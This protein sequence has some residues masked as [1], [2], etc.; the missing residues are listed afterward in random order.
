[1]T[2]TINGVSWTAE[3]VR[4]GAVLAGNAMTIGA[5]SDDRTSINFSAP[6]ALG[7]VTLGALIPAS[8]TLV[9]RS[10]AVATGSWT[11][12]GSQGGGSITVTTITN[13][14]ATGTFLFTMVPIVGTGASG[15]RIVANGTF[16]VRFSTPT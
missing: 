16:T 10:G 2:A 7:T 1:M 11:A 5:T 4:G 12:G 9:T 14:G 15:N 3:V 13:D 6:A 8:A